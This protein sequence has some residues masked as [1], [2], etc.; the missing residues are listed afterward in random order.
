MSLPASIPYYCSRTLS[1]KPTTM[2]DSLPANRSRMVGYSRVH[3]IPY[4]RNSNCLLLVIASHF[5]NSQHPCSR[6]PILTSQSVCSHVECLPSC[7]PTAETL[8]PPG[9]CS[10]PSRSPELARSVRITFLL[11][12]AL[13]QVNVRLDMRRF[14]GAQTLLVARRACDRTFFSIHKILPRN[15]RSPGRPPGCGVLQRDVCVPTDACVARGPGCEPGTVVG[16]PSN[17]REF[18][19]GKSNSASGKIAVAFR[20]CRPCPRGVPPR[21]VCRTG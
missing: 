12:P 1:V 15:H 3:P 5:N 2:K 7:S 9:R 6:Q 20:Y 18:P 19:R 10:L 8:W 16:G 21:L 11:A 13:H 4:S 17:S 14:A